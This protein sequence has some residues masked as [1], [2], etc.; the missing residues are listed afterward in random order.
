MAGD[1]KTKSDK[2]YSLVKTLKENDCGIDG[3]GFQNHIDISFTDENIEA[4]RSNI[5]RY[6]DINITVHIT[7]TDVRC[8]QSGDCNQTTWSQSMLQRQADIY[9]KLLQVCLEEP[10]CTNFESWG[11][12]DAYSFLSAP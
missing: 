3:V 7:E 12:T 6:N 9:S 5:Q 1:Y 11:F 8:N 10:N 4:I 2:V